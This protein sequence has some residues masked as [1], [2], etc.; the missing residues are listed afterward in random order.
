MKSAAFLNGLISCPVHGELLTSRGDEWVAPGSG[1][2]YRTIR[3]VPVLR[4]GPEPVQAPFDHASNPVHPDLWHWMRSFDGHVLFLGAGA[5]DERAEQVVEVEY[6]LFRNTDVLADAHHLPFRD[7]VFAAAVALNV[8]EHLREPHRAAAEIH[9]VLRPH[10][11][12]MI[13]TAFLQPL[14]EAPHH[15]YNATEFGVAN[16]FADFSDVMCEV[17]PNFNPAFNLSWLMSETLDC[18]TQ[19]LGVREG[20][21]FANLT[22]REAAAFWRTRRQSDFT[23]ALLA[24]PD[25]MVR[26]LAG[27]FQLKARK[28]LS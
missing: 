18:V 7:G 23:R 27:G 11:E 10:G 15:Y 25:H 5:S 12:V 9:R 13:H 14:H 6:N 16:W 2:T 24:L 17:S 8:F 4:D 20:E 3:G 1:R 26:R 28:P 19:A 21:R 22:V